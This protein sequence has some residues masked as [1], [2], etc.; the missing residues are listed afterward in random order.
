MKQFFHLVVGSSLIFSAADAQANDPSSISGRIDLSYSEANPDYSPFSN[1][2][3]L[4]V[5]GRIEYDEKLLALYRQ[6]D[7]S[8]QPSGPVSG[9]EIDLWRELGLGYQ[10]SLSEKWTLEGI[11]SYQEIEQGSN[12]ESGHEIQIGVQFQPYQVVNFD[13]SLGRL[14]LQIDDW[15]LDF[16]TRYTAFENVYITAKLRDYADWDFT[17]YEFGLGLDF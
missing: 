5:Y 15:N 11:L 1:G 12:N 2:K 4:G 6:S 7:A 3:G 9:E 8:F 17:Y 13:L 10:H 16:E 14:D